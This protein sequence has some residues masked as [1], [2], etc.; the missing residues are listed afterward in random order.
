[1]EAFHLLAS[2]L[3]ATSAAT[4]VAAIM[5]DRKANPAIGGHLACPCHPIGPRW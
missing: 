4:L 5:A 2:V 1:M 3:S